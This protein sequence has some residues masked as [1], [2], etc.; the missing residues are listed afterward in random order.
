[1]TVVK[2]TTFLYVVN[3]QKAY[4]QNDQFIVMDVY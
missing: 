4:A 1:M 3:V 2:A